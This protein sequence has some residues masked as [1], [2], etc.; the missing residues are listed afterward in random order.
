MVLPTSP[1]LFPIIPAG[2]TQLEPLLSLFGPVGT[3]AQLRILAM[4]LPTAV[5][6]LVFPCL[7]AM[8]SA[9]V[10]A[11]FSSLPTQAKELFTLLGLSQLW[12]GSHWLMGTSQH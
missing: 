6:W 9:Q 4:C 11:G 3:W 10:A 5:R 1:L 8:Q 12:P 2:R 7:L